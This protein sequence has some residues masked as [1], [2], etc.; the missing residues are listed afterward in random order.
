MPLKDIHANISFSSFTF[1]AAPWYLVKQCKREHYTGLIT[2]GYEGFKNY[3][4]LC[5]EAGD[6]TEDRTAKWCTAISALKPA[7]MD[8][9]TQCTATSST[10]AA[11][12][13]VTSPTA[14]A[15][16]SGY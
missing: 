9:P 1:K 3:I 13:V 12:S 16:P 14:T 8:M 6:I 11:A 10:T 15:S 2:D 4:E 5:I 7:D